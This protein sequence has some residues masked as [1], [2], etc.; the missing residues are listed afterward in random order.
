MKSK[1]IVK[2]T[3]NELAGIKELVK[4]CRMQ[5]KCEKCPFEPVCHDYGSMGQYMGRILKRIESDSEVK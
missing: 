4:H 2:A 5:P 1:T 3:K